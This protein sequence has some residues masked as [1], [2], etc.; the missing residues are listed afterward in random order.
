MHRD[1]RALFACLALAM[2]LV[3]A[4]A[5]AQDG[6]RAVRGMQRV[7]AGRADPRLPVHVTADPWRGLG[8]VESEAGRRCTGA[9]VGE[10][11]V[12]TAAH[13]LM[14]K[15]GDRMLPPRQVR[16]LLAY[17]RGRSDAQSRVASYSLGPGFRADPPGPALSDWALL[18]LEQPLGSPAQVMPLLP[19]PAPRSPAM[20][21][22][23]QQ[24]RPEV[25]I[26]DTRCS[27][28]AAED[29]GLRHDCAGSRQAGG[30]PVLVRNAA[31]QW[32][33]AGVVALAPAEG[34]APAA[35]PASRVSLPLPGR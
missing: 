24:D 6:A 17:D 18:T 30:A 7:G 32:A 34:D 14:A 8:R 21:G 3:P 5:A 4:V 2:V 22:G 28:I 25:L 19:A 29:A 11:L 9:L 13:C 12:L 35:V 23:Y 20:L 16:F 10:K 27:V 15:S 33:I 1:S 26:A 31:G